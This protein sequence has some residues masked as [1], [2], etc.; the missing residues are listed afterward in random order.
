MPRPPKSVAARNQSSHRV[1]RVGI[2]IVSSFEPINSLQDSVDEPVDDQHR[3]RLFIAVALICVSFL[4]LV[5]QLY[6]M[7]VLQGDTY[8][9][10][11]DNNRFRLSAIEAPRGVVYDRNRVLL[12]RNRPTYTIG[13][14]E[15]DLPAQP[16]PVYR[17]LG[18]LLGVQASDVQGAFEARRGDRF[19]LV[20][21]RTNVPQDLAFIVEERHS[22]LPGVHVV[23]QPNREYL[24]GSLMSHII[25]YTGRITEEQYGAL[26]DDV[27]GRYGI[28]DRV[29]QTGIEA[30]YE[31]ELR[32]SPGERRM[33]VDAAGREVRILEVDEPTSGRNLVLTI[34]S[35]LQKKAT[36]LLSA[37][38]DQ[39]GTASVVALDP[40]TG[41]VLALVHL[42]SYDDNLFSRGITQSELDALLTDQRKPLVNGA[43]G[44]AYSPGA[45]FTLITGAGALQEGIVKSDTKVRCDGGLIVP[46]RLDPTVG[47]KFGDTGAYGEQD[48]VGAL[49][50]QCRTFFYL[51]GGGD[52]DGKSDGLGVAGLTRYARMF[53]FGL[54]SGIALDGEAQGFIG[55][56]EWKKQEHNEVW[57]K[58]DTYQTAIG[59]DNLLVTPLQIANAIATIANGG[60]LYKPHLVREFEET[61]ARGVS[62]RIAVAPEPLRRVDVSP[63]N[64]A[65]LREALHAATQTGRT[66]NGANYNG[67]A[68]S[69]DVPGVSIG[70]LVA[71]VEYAP[72]AKK[73][74]P[75]LTH[76][77][78]AGFGPTEQSR[79]ALVVF[80]ERGRG[81]DAAA[82][83]RQILQDYLERTKGGGS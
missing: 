62:R 83:G 15:A 71:S 43:I 8:R 78:F 33:E 4:V 81:E 73:G 69:A 79:I 12:A 16:E 24:S 3:L 10:R 66:S 13:I 54:A 65:I 18:S 29:G 55:S 32:G 72:P 46:S 57:Y 56:P 68:R 75:P 30:S 76:A 59:E 52:P 44:A 41:Q 31:Q 9:A 80:L 14:I 36:E 74:D 45:L 70:G 23:V 48:I 27:S 40:N 35:E 64:L 39:Y 38:L 63:E 17:R 53:N 61:D 28:N 37:K 49:A 1:H 19:T 22:E 2:R 26:K 77:W 34:D 25:G 60:T 7:Q 20:P 5:G 82:I 11:A 50:N 51:A 21:I 47:T 6:R 58:G 42:P 67:V